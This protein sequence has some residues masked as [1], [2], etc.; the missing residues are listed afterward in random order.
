MSGESYLDTRAALAHSDPQTSKVVTILDALTIIFT[1]FT[2]V[3]AI[4]A[5]YAA[6][7]QAR[8]SH[9]EARIAEQSL[10]EQ[11]L[12]LREQTERARL[13]LEVDLMYK[14]DERFNS[15]RFHHYR[16][17]SLRH[18]KEHYF[19]GD[20]LAEAPELDPATEQLIDF[21]DEVGYLVRNG[22]VRVE[23]VWAGWP[24]LPSAWA[25]WEPA[26]KKLRAKYGS[27]HRYQDLE[28]LHNKFVGLE[29]QRGVEF[30][31]PTVADL[32]EF[33]DAN[34]E[35]NETAEEPPTSN[36]TSTSG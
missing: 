29:R 34:L 20:G 2:A 13:S 32:K 25:I 23:R 15:K 5:A 31:P 14:L 16:I 12:S 4:W 26:I 22:A 36:E 28:Y 18:I 33:V 24:G 27:P 11:I 6:T 1:S 35:Y 19:V 21:F 7:H 10:H 17:R 3:G 9:L 30:E 8:A